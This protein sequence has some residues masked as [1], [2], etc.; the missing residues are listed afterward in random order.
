M[1][2]LDNEYATVYVYP[3]KKIVHH[4]FHKYMFGE[5]FH[6]VMLAGADAFEKYGCNKWLSDDRGNSA[7]R[8]EDTD[9]GQSVWE[10]R[11]IKAGWK[12]WAL[13]M[14]NKIIGQMDMTKLVTRYRNLGVTVQV[15]HNDK[16][17]MAWLERQ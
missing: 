2:L 4:Q 13:V 5:T 12:Y 9:W 1:K 6:K 14:P 10:P 17:A 8:K 7:I 16:E 11:V 3:D 15:F